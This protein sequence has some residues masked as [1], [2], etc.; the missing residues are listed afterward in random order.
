MVKK[1]TFFVKN[2]NSFYPVLI[3][4]VFV[5][6]GQYLM[7]DNRNLLFGLLFFAVAVII[8]LLSFFTKKIDI[9]SL[10]KDEKINK[11]IEIILLLAIILIGIFFRVYMIK[12]VPAGCY[13][14]EGQN[15]NEAINIMN[16][17][18]LDGTSLPVYIERWTQNAAMYM[19]FVA[20]SFKF[21]GIG[22]LQIRLVSIIFGILC[23][24][25]FYFLLRYIFGVKLALLGAFLIA[26]LRWHVNFS[27]IGFLGIL[28]VF[29]VILCFYFAWRTYKE[30]KLFDFIILGVVTALS[31]YTYL[32][33]R[34][35]PVAFFIFLFF[36]L[37][38]DFKFYKQN[39][40]KML[41]GLAAF[42]IVGFPLFK[43]AIKH[44]Q[45]FTSR[46]SAVSIF[47]LEML[48]E[49]GGRYVE[50][51][52]QP[53]HWTKLYIENVWR[54]LMMFNWQGDGNPRHNY[55]LKP[56]L[57]FVT[58]IFFVA[59]FAIMLFKIFAPL[60]FLLFAFFISMLQAGLLSTESPQ[61]YRTIGLI[62]IVL[63][64]TIIGFQ[65][66]NQ[67][68]KEEFGKKSNLY[69]IAFLL[70]LSGY[71][72]YENYDKYFNGFAKNPGSWAEF[73]SDEYSMGRYV[74]SLGDN[75]IAIIDPAWMNSYTFK[76]AVYPYKNYVEFS[77]SEWIPIKAKVEKNFTYILDDTYLPL[78][79]VF[80]SMYPNG[81]YS[82]FRHKFFNS[83]ILYFTYEVPYEDVKKQQDKP[84]KNGL[85]G[86]YYNG[87]EWKDPP[88]FTRL[89]PFI[90]FNWTVDPI[91]GKFS[92]KWTGKIKIDIPGEYTFITKSNDYSDL[93]IDGKVVLKNLGGSGL[94]A[95]AGKINLTKGLHSVV[96]RYYES[97]H[98]SKMQFWWRKPGTTEEEVVPS[99]VLLPQ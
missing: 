79:P 8:L 9:Y 18:V 86:S 83:K 27:R 94:N 71:I 84:V 68:I 72:G 48:R 77:P 19:Y 22:V 90:L 80:K 99:E 24:P 43:Y 14:D 60:N 33:S 51:D 91:M 35:I 39:W 30:R 10:Q 3:S 2:I 96:L 50:K 98:Y 34:L 5:F 47:N 89:D 6:I 40:K 55:A 1:K 87:I 31:L 67:A 92:V 66:L 29:F 7:Y 32:A 17:V 58:G 25:A 52:G 69:F 4:F 88:V 15:G 49:I 75:Y 93:M 44:P 26:V 36:L 38:K 11:K 63:I 53:K 64:L 45:Y 57:D 42:F 21:F 81:K 37:F 74:H 97:L 41:I 73:S 28:T 16:G 85:M 12:D 76:F 95:V 56:M 65:V 54:T 59:G 23:I 62:P 20:V 13:R 82:D 61:A 78:L 70:L 46:Q